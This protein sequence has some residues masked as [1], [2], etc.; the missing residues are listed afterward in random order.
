MPGSAEA[1]VAPA[2]AAPESLYEKLKPGPGRS[3]SEVAEHQRA[4]IQAAMLKI[5]AE[6]GY[7]AVTVRDLAQRASV[8]SRAFYKHYSGK[9]ECFLCTHDSI[10]QRIDR[11]VSVAQQGEL[12]WRECLR[13]TIDTYLRELQR[14]PY[15]ARLLL[16]DSYIAGPPA[17]GHVRRAERALE[18]R[19]V[20]CFDLAA[21]G[22]TLPS[23]VARGMAG[24]L[25]CVARTRLAKDQGSDLTGLTDEL[26][27]W[28]SSVFTTAQD[29]SCSDNANPAFHQ[30]DAPM[31]DDQH[32]SWPVV[33]E[34][35]L[36]VM[37]LAKL[38]AVEKYHELTV[39]KI[40]HSAGASRKKF[41]THFTDVADCFKEAVERYRT[42]TISRL[43]DDGC[44]EDDESHNAGSADPIAVVC[45]WATNDATFASI[46]FADIFGPGVGG[47]E[48]LDRIIEELQA[49]LAESAIQA[50]G[51]AV[52]L[53]VSAAAIWAALREEILAG[54]RARLL[55][56]ASQL[57]VLA[58]VR[59]LGTEIE[60]TKP[61]NLT[62]RPRGGMLATR[63]EHLAAR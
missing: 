38:V 16:I 21:G 48:C 47:V 39:R 13:L 37:A 29:V 10:A 32:S 43:A 30:G 1:L 51:S 9:E 58:P 18:T 24:G 8:S 28:A 20:D 15:A 5:V 31:Q 19:L 49:A 61:K 53:E 34:R 46:C 35:S 6:R 36:I 52:V 17:L 2:A 44:R 22:S 3:A 14:E 33:D 50:N 63:G 57:Q 42:S 4:R 62:T 41:S 54:R 25:I 23:L 59:P 12:G 7:R 55:E 40:R 26:T 27:A 45:E 60:N 11:R 56:S